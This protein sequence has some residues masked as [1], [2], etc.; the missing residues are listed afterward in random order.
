MAKKKALQLQRAAR[1]LK[2]AKASSC[3]THTH[4]FVKR[5]I[6]VTVI[7]LRGEYTQSGW[8]T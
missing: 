4:F 3:H 8:E 7:I 5:Q 6:I 1:I 2:R